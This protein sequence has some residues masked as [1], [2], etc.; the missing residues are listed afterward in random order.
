MK[1]KYLVFY[2]CKI[3]LLKN[4]LPDLYIGCLKL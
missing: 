1:E 2:C 4:K 3:A